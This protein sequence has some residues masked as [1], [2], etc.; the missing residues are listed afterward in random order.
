M[1]QSVCPLAEGLE[2][3]SAEA[4]GLVESSAPSV[5]YLDEASPCL[6]VHVVLVGPNSLLVCVF[7]SLLSI[8]TIQA[9]P[10][11]H[12]GPPRIGCAAE[13]FDLIH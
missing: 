1:P 4:D 8:N 2:G 13:R 5:L 9:K 6:S 11:N 3:V 12:H 10:Q 7:V